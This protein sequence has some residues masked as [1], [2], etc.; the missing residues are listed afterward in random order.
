MSIV[1][2]VPS[3][4]E[5]EIANGR[6]MVHVAFIPAESVAVV[7]PL[8]EGVRT[9]DWL[10]YSKGTRPKYHSKSWV[11]QNLGWRVQAMEKC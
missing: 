5:L 3:G 6:V 8:V 4:E 9:M 10:K 7:P 2:A 11:E 1:Y